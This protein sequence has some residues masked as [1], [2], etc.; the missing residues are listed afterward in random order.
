MLEKLPKVSYF[1]NSDILSQNTLYCGL[2]STLL[3]LKLMA[4]SKI[5]TNTKLLSNK[6]FHTL[7]HYLFY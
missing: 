4:F 5:Y 3:E 2:K 1:I 6:L 7:L